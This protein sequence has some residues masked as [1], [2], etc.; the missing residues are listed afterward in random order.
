M[1][2]TYKSH[3]EAADTRITNF[4]SEP[5][6]DLKNYKWVT[7]GN[8][9]LRRIYAWRVPPHWSRGDW[10]EEVRAEV[11]AA[12]W[13]AVCNFDPARG[14]PLSAFVY[15]Q[16]LARALTRYRREWAY[17]V[18][19][20]FQSGEEGYGA[21]VGGLVDPPA[22]QEPMRRALARLSPPDKWLIEQLFW[23][24]HTEAETSQRLGISQQAVSK[25]KR[26]ILQK[27]HGWLVAPKKF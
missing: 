21:R 12:A 16:V 2:I 26:S 3:Q 18:R 10:F 23:E 11:E 7:Q 6:F 9:P 25:R 4:T 8:N 1:S 15:Q 20:V 19:C 14:V 17:A 5:V 13:Q 22:V 27:L 24:G